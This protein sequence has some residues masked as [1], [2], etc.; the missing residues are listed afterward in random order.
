MYLH[1]SLDQGMNNQKD[2][3]SEKQDWEKGSRLKN[4]FNRTLYKKNQIACIICSSFFFFL[5]KTFIL[6]QIEYVQ[7]L[8]DN[9]ACEEPWIIL[10]TQVSR[11]QPN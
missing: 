5:I 10:S 9:T 1:S 6:Q 7:G 4:C 8:V 2:S 11:E 3:Y